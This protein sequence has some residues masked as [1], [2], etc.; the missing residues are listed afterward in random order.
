ME[1]LSLREFKR[2]F[3]KKYL[4]DIYYDGKAKEF[5][6]LKMGSMTDE[7]YT[8]KFQELLWYVPYLMDEKTKVQRFM[9]L[10]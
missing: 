1:E 8:T 10:L 5:Y 4:V 3:R 6:K 9:Y 7:E 2:P